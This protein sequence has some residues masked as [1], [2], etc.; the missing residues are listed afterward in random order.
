MSRRDPTQT[1][2]LRRQY[3]AQFYKRFR[4]LKGLVRRGVGE[5]DRLNFASHDH[6]DIPDPSDVHPD[7]IP[8]GELPPH[9]PPGDEEALQ[10]FMD[11]YDNT[12][13]AV[14]LGRHP[15]EREEEGPHWSEKYVRSVYK[16]GAQ[17]AE[18][19]MKRLLGIDID[20][21]TAIAPS[22]DM[23]IHRRTIETLL[24]R[25]MRALEGVTNA[26]SREVGRVLADGLVSGQNPRQIARDIN[27]R[28]DAVGINRA[29]THS[30]TMIVESYNDATLN[31]YEQIMGEDGAVTLQAEWLTADD[32]RVCPDCQGMSGEILTIS[33]AKGM[34]PFHPNCR[35]TW[36]PVAEEGRESR[37]PTPV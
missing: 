14:V 23:P 28:I 11:W 10:W 34:I 27:D 30:R 24:Q 19:R 9:L 13:M 29:R 3:G 22:L 16:K 33:E 20:H 15:G 26:T 6:D 17:D 4:R 25:N 36:R 31:R 7:E 8:E 21:R 5:E 18:E 32:D 37:L 1:T 12:Q 35:C 2:R